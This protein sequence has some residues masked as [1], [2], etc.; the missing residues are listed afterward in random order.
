MTDR[1]EA[2]SILAAVVDAGSLSA[3]ARA[4]RLPLATVSRKVADLEALLSTQLLLRSA[5]GLR[6]T[7]A[8]AAYLLAARRILED[9]AEAERAARGEFSAPRGTLT[10]T[11]PIVFGRLHVLPVV[12]AFLRDYPEVTVRLE[13][14]DRA[15]NLHEERVD[16]ALR[17]GSLPDSNLIARRLGSVTRMVCASPDYLAARGTPHKPEDITT[18]DCVTFGNLMSATRWRFG[19]GRSETSIPVRSRL[20]TNTAEAAIDAAE[21]GLGLTRVLSYQVAD[22][23]HSGRLCR[24]LTEHEPEPWPVSL[25]YTPRELLPQK[26]RAFLDFAG[27][28]IER[29]LRSHDAA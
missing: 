9:V 25:I 6:P 14:S 26:L 5:R 8:G 27:P 24:V 12:T 16:L 7:D 2:M 21:A 15:V 3:G 13:Q 4:L 29:A 1:F 10:I 11:A 22:A 20:V 19:H 17:I 28:R 23:I 18:H